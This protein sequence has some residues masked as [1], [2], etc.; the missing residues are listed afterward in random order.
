MCVTL[1]YLKTAPPPSPL[2]SCETP[3][4]TLPPL[5]SPSGETGDRAE[6]VQRRKVCLETIAKMLANILKH[7]NEKKFRVD[8]PPTLPSLPCPVPPSSLSPPPFPPPPVPPA[9]YPVGWLVGCG[10]AAF[11]YQTM[12]FEQKLLRW[13]VD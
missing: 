4:I 5:P 9:L 3:I 13:M 7:P 11:D 1:Q 2:L 8:I 12:L 6:D 10:V